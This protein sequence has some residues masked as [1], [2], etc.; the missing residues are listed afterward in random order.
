MTTSEAAAMLGI[1]VN[2]LANLVWR[3]QLTP[4]SGTWV[5]NWT[6]SEAEIQRRIHERN[7]GLDRSRAWNGARPK[8]AVG[9]GA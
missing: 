3:K 5:H 8:H 2:S 4:E 7:V 1:A 6:F 9:A